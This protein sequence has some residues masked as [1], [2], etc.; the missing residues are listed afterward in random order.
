VK[1]T[2]TEAVASQ[3]EE[4][5][6]LRSEI[7]QAQAKGKTDAEKQLAKTL[8]DYDAKYKQYWEQLGAQ[9]K[10]Y[11]D[12]AAQ[13][14]AKGQPPPEPP[15]ALTN[16]PVPPPSPDGNG[17]G[18]NSAQKLLQAAAMAACI[19]YPPACALAAILPN[20]GLFDSEEHRQAYLGVLQKVV[21]GQTPSPDDLKKLA[22]ALA[23]SKDPKKVE[24][25]V[26][27]VENAL[28]PAA[29]AEATK[30]LSPYW[31]KLDEIAKPG[32]PERVQKLRKAMSDAKSLM[33]VY[34]I[35]P[36]V[37]GKPV[38]DNK[39]EYDRTE[40]LCRGNPQFFEA[41]WNTGLKNVPVRP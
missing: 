24:Q 26:R 3:K 39:N 7:A 30:A 37:D 32:E 27:Q 31:Q 6:K 25:F 21:S 16:P 8:A 29:K 23:A 38:F 34:G 18:D 35:L 19:Y 13:N 11:G 40:V 4:L 36:Q 41:Y 28:P 14:V 33:D 20:L 2:L 9:I 1:R 22:D 5:N 12:K 17:G 15:A 10:E